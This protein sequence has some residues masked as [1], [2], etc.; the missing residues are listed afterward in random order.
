MK[1]NNFVPL[2]ILF[3]HGMSINYSSKKT[4]KTILHYSIQN[5]KQFF[6][7]LFL[8]VKSFNAFIKDSNGEIPLMYS[9]I[10]NRKNIFLYM[11]NNQDIL[12]SITNQYYIK[13][14][15]YSSI[16][17][18]SNEYYDCLMR[19][20]KF[21]LIELINSNEI[22]TL[23][24]IMTYVPFDAFGYQIERAIIVSFNNR[25]FRSL[26]RLFVCRTL[27][28]DS[29]NFDGEIRYTNISF[30]TFHCNLISNVIEFYHEY[31]RRRISKKMINYHT[32]YHHFF[33]IYYYN[34]DWTALDGYPYEYTV[35]YN[36][37]TIRLYNNHKP[38]SPSHIIV[39]LF[40]QI[41]KKKKIQL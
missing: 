22:D 34:E 9:I 6:V 13:M 2:F 19:K 11:M 15:F 29:I 10:Y 20:R 35:K 14:Y 17:K 8:S 18:V 31:L 38:N 23:C 36:K 5:G 7:K 30:E 26:T 21:D 12:K 27:L 32:L 28:E 40:A 41:K 16:F 39:N 3:N 1:S 25:N 33:T 4:R 37:K 24:N